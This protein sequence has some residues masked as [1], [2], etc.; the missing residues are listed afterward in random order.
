[1]SFWVLYAKTVSRPFD[2]YKSMQENKV[3]ELSFIFYDNYARDTE[4]LTRDFKKVEK[5][6]RNGL[7]KVNE[8]DNKKLN[9]AYQGFTERMKK[10]L[11]DIK[12]QPMPLKIN[13]SFKHSCTLNDSSIQKR[14]R[15]E[16]TNVPLS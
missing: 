11:Q 9:S 12:D 8:K 3:G 10:R 16:C 4:R 14:E 15:E 6:Y 1:V 13:M 2:V 7:Q 5:I